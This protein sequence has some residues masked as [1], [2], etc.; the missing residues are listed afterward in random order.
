MCKKRHE[1]L[2][3]GYRGCNLPPNV[4]VRQDRADRC[5]A[6]IRERYTRVHTCG[7]GYE[8]RRNPYPNR[9]AD[10][11]TG[12][13][14]A[15]YHDAITYQPTWGRGRELTRGPT[16]HCLHTAQRGVVKVW[17][18]PPRP[19]GPRS[20]ITSKPVADAV[21]REPRRECARRIARPS[22][23]VGAGAP[24]SDPRSHSRDNCFCLCVMERLPL[25]V[26]R[27][28]RNCLQHGSVARACNC[29]NY[30]ATVRLC[31]SRTSTSTLHEF[32][33]SGNLS[34]KLRQCRAD[35]A[36]PSLT[37]Q[38]MLGSCARCPT[39]GSGLRT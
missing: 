5:P 25:R 38:T 11:G 15:L 37:C 36:P 23:A 6:C 18:R 34:L 31:D 33:A 9:N 28:A 17:S 1:R 12:C 24:R 2:T 4:N 32:S 26:L 27:D 35:A 19:P 16:E 13:N 29:K 21:W 3:C 8:Y 7:G 22:P 14:L 10:C 30:T 39:T 20:T